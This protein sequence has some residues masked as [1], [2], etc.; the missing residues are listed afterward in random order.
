MNIG[1]ITSFAIGGLLLVTILT[2]NRQLNST[3][4]EMVL[5]TI[6]QSSRNEIVTL[7]TNDFSKIG[8]KVY[9]AD[10]FTTIESEDVIFKADVFDGDSHGVQSVRWYLDRS[11]SVTTTTNPN[12]YYLKR[13]G[14]IS[15]SVANG[16]LKFPVT[17]F[18]VD[19]FDSA[20]DS[21]TN[22]Y[23]VR[24][25]QVQ[26]IVESGEPHSAS[27]NWQGSYARNFWKKLFIPDNINSYTE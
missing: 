18:Q 14:P 4:E 19:Y 3:G 1:L 21:T 12:D 2:F 11:D 20:G 13:V 17:H 9:T 23:R 15:N 7:I 24:R 25:V 16:T 27:A 26:F 6:N 10:V 8:Y 22:E 5:N